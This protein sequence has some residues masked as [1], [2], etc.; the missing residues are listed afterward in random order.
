MSLDQKN[1]PLLAQLPRPEA[2]R[3]PVLVSS[4]II[5]LAL[6]SFFL[7]GLLVMGYRLREPYMITTLLQLLAGVVAFLSV[8]DGRIV[9]GVRIFVVSVFLTLMLEPYVVSDKTFPYSLVLL[10]PGLLALVVTSG[11]VFDLPVSVGLAVLAASNT[12]LSYFNALRR[13]GPLADWLPEL[14]PV[15]AV[16]VLMS[17]LIVYLWVRITRGLLQRG[18]RLLRERE[19]LIQETNHRVKNNL[20]M[21]TSVLDLQRRESRESQVTYALEVA[22]ARIRAVAAVHQALHVT[23]SEGDAELIPFLE[24]L[25]DAIGE[26][27]G[28][29]IVAI[30]LAAAPTPVR[31]AGRA[32]V[33]LAL[34]L[35]E[36]ISNAAQHGHSQAGDTE[37]EVSVEVT[38]GEY[39]F[40]VQDNG[41]GF[42]DGFDPRRQASLG[43]TL[44]FALA[45]EQLDGSVTFRSDPGGV[46]TIGLPQ[47]HF[48]PRQG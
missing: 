8:L 22:G 1:R 13:P 40:S 35:N 36:L 41:R 48:L 43:L 47:E 10:P 7:Q 3:L 33:P 34:V 30:R 29:R 28:E 39:R 21:I 2:V 24:K 9:G 46:V 19:L 5:T 45:E 31:I 25:I 44:V 23:G 17:A 14:I 26:S 20:Q 15:V 37:I 16:L 12:A 27:V 18:S 32:M 42:A 4:L 38:Q 6:L 11:L